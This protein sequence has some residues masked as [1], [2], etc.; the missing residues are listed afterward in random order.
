[1]EW[2]GNQATISGVG[3]SGRI[4][5]QAKKVVVEV[6]LGILAK[7][8]GVDAKRLEESIRRRLTEALAA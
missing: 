1:V 7:A 6:K 3:A 5:V 8:A 4:D 2:W